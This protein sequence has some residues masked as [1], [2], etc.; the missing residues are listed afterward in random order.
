MTTTIKQQIEN[1][2]SLVELC[3]AINSFEYSHDDGRKLDEIVD[4]SSL[5]TFG[6]DDIDR[7][8]AW[9]WDADNVL[10]Q[11]TG[12]GDFEIETREWFFS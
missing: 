2:T 1:A 5:P 10:V 9:S 12:T 7:I 4:M 6:G 11:D 3:D 8:G